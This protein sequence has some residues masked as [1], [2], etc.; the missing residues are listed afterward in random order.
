VGVNSV[1]FSEKARPGLTFRKTFTV[2][3]GAAVPS[4]RSMPE[5]QSGH[6]DT[7][8]RTPQMV[9]GSASII[10]LASYDLMTPLL[11]NNPAT[12]TGLLP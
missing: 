1:T 9:A 2:L 4:T 5:S 6:F 7:S 11:R 12:V 3:P 10:E 8:V